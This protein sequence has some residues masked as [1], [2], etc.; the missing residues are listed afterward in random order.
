MDKAASGAVDSR[1]RE[2]A[3]K[4]DGYVGVCMVTLIEWIKQWHGPEE[5]RI[6]VAMMR[7]LIENRHATFEDD[8]G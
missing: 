7:A 6:R 1:S 5:S 4:F 8:A 3:H 2:I